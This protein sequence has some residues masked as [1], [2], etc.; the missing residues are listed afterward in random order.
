M[1]LP[2]EAHGLVASKY[3]RKEYGRG[4]SSLGTPHRNAKFGEQSY[5]VEKILRH[6]KQIRSLPYECLRINE[7][8]PP[9]IQQERE[10][11][12]VQKPFHHRI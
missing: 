5:F 11:Y 6:V 8:L 1:Y 7:R 12:F 2:L 3:E 9:K 4:P 10:Q